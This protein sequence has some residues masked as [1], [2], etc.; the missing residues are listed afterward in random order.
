MNSTFL[1]YLNQEAKFLK[2]FLNEN[3]KNILVNA[4]ID[5]ITNNKKKNELYLDLDL[6]GIGDDFYEF[7]FK[8]KNLISK[9]KNEKYIDYIDRLIDL[10]KTELGKNNIKFLNLKPKSDKDIDCAN[11]VDAENKYAVHTVLESYI[12]VNPRERI[13]Y[14][15]TF[16]LSNDN[17]FKKL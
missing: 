13:K 6:S 12:Y 3:E 1:Y 2:N 11:I 7:I 8:I 10:I 4:T 17:I 9:D 15:M 14:L 5:Y 16:L